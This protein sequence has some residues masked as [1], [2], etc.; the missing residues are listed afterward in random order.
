MR[1]GEALALGKRG[2]A[3]TV[4]EPPKATDAGI[5][6]K[7]ITNNELR[8][9]I[10]VEPTGATDTKEGP[11]PFSQGQTRLFAA[12]HNGEYSL[13]AAPVVAQAEETATQLVSKH[14]TLVKLLLR[15]KRT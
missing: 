5:E 1:L 7:T 3:I 13:N 2:E 8:A 9:G 14:E 11:A 10:A 4:P 15:S 6:I 12:I